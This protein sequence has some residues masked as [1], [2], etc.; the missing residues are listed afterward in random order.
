MS[1]YHSTP[2]R[3]MSRPCGTGLSLPISLIASTAPSFDAPLEN[4]ALVRVYYP[5]HAFIDGHAVRPGSRAATGNA[6][7]DLP[8]SGSIRNTLFAAGTAIQY[9][10]LK[11]GARAPR[12]CVAALGAH[13]AGVEPLLRACSTASTSPRPWIPFHWS[14][15][16]PAGSCLSSIVSTARRYRK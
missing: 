1:Q 10:P 9:L 12:R 14:S 16:D 11:S 7:H 4:R 5:Q 13:A 8:V 15:V 3:S 2:L 6:A